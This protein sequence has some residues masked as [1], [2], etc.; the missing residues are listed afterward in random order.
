[1]KRI[2][3]VMMKD[4][5]E[6]ELL[7]VWRVDGPH[8]RLINSMRETLGDRD[9]TGEAEEIVYDKSAW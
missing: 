4:V 1:M 6:S 9:G 5:F 8:K 3:S 7:C 2:E